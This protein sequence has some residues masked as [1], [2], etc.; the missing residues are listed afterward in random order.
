[1]AAMSVRASLPTPV[2][3]SP[4]LPKFSEHNPGHQRLFM[5]CKLGFKRC[6]LL[7]CTVSSTKCRQVLAYRLAA[8]IQH[9]C[10]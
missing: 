4:M 9:L 2:W 10:A 8:L 6:F 5:F 7:Y 1:M 3:V